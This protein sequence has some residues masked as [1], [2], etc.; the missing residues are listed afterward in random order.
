MGAVPNGTAADGNFLP[1]RAEDPAC[2]SGNAGALSG[3]PI[4]ALSKRDSVSGVR[5][6][7][8]VSGTARTAAV[9][10]EEDQ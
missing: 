1:V 8:G 5:P 9:A 6:E 4:S 10:A 7:S 2:M 3:L